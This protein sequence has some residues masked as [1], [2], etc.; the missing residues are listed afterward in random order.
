MKENEKGEGENFLCQDCYSLRTPCEVIKIKTKTKGDN[1]E[2]S[3]RNR[4]N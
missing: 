3:D 1:K 4:E 2:K